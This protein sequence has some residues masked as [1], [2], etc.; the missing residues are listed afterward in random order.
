MENLSLNYL[1]TACI[2][3]AQAVLT[4]S[5]DSRMPFSLLIAEF[6]FGWKQ[7]FKPFPF[8]A[9]KSNPGGN[10]KADCDLKHSIFIQTKTYKN[11]LL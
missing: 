11:H 6:S 10:E 2:R 1:S 8:S 9:A 3:T 5:A 4:S 7:S